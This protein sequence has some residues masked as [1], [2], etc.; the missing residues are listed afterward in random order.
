MLEKDV[1]G[2]AMT[3]KLSRALFRGALLLAVQHPRSVSPAGQA[4]THWTG[5]AVVP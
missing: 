4:P 5:C 1:W 2:S 3:S